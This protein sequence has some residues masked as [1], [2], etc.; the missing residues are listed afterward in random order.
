MTKIE[1]IE[2]KLNELKCQIRNTVEG[3][4]ETCEEFEI[5][6][7]ELKFEYQKALA[8]LKESKK[9]GKWKPAYDEVYFYRSDNGIVTE[10]C[11]YDNQF[12]EW[13]FN[14]LQIFK[15]E[16]ECERYWHF[17]DTVKEKSYE[18][19]TDEWEDKTICKWFIQYETD[20]G[21]IYPNWDYNMIRHFGK[22]YF[23]DKETAQY[24]IDNF[25]DELMEYFL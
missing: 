13:R 15:T 25:K 17:M 5:E 16:E 14:N 3:F 12:D 9:E 1:E 19:S 7:H 23:K 11:C 21:D 22:I 2:Q 20:N 8:E 24:I 18:F 6:I 10:R 4:E